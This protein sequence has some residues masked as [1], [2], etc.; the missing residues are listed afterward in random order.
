MADPIRQPMKYIAELF[1]PNQWS[2]K[3]AIADNTYS[4]QYNIYAFSIA[5]LVT[6]P[7]N[8][9]I[10]WGGTFDNP[11]TG[12]LQIYMSGFLTEVFLPSNLLVTDNSFY[13][14][15]STNV[16]YMNL[17]QNPWRYFTEYAS[18]YGNFLST[19][20]TSPKDETNLSDVYYDNTKIDVRMK[21]PSMES[22]LNDVIS[23]VVVYD[24]FSIQVDNS[25]G[26]YDGLNILS[27]FNTPLQVSKSDSNPQHIYDFDRIRYGI[28]SDVKVEFNNLTIE[29]ADQ[30][31][32]MN[33]E[34]CKKF[35]T[36][37]YPN[38]SDSD[39]NSDIPVGW[40]VLY[41]I[42]PI[43]VSKDTADPATW[44]DYIALD[45]DYITAVSGVY[46]KDGNSL[47]HTFTAST[48]IIRVTSV[49]GDGEVIEAEYMNVTGKTDCNIAEI[50]TFAL[51]A[52]ESLTYIE[53]IWDLTETNS[54]L[55][56]C[57]D[58]SVYFDGGTTKELVE[59]VLKNDMAY[60]I[61]KND[62]RLTIRR[63][64]ETYT[65]HQIESWTITDKPK[66][67]FED[68]TKY[69]CSS[70]K[71][72]YNQNYNGDYFQNSYLYDTDER[73][74]FGKFRKSYLATFETGLNNSTDAL[75][76]S[77]RLI[78]RFGNIRETVELSLGV[79]TFDINLLDTIEIEIQLG[80]PAREFS[81]YSK[82]IVK[83]INP[84][85]DEFTVEG[86]EIYN[87]LTFD[88]L[89]ATLDGVQFVINIS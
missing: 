23:G 46:D 20:A 79:N 82:W 11:V 86:I 58:V 68:A 38:I 35:N 44:I 71:I 4:R 30:L 84:G 52:N 75:D 39:V 50:L 85:Q 22:T 47:T 53:G 10:V 45:P 57:P 21:V 2:P 14:D 33:K 76:L 7:T 87:P 49:D 67:N 26:A 27:Y 1:Q 69:F 55:A 41:G 32:M 13:V 37:D 3:L 8:Y 48:G 70:V 83:G 54:Y 31:Y 81:P 51:E 77:E 88:G 65:N 18:I 74:I 43:E 5:P 64:G 59:T 24:T 16:C 15:D 29:A 12:S 36:T 89:P 28:V 19:F 6:D 66:K 62:G 56:I 63:W 78:E 80:N 25:D 9:W 42:E 73:E 17:P 60:L 40:G 34:Y 61:Q 72:D